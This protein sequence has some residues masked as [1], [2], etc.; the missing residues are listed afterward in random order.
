MIVMCVQFFVGLGSP[1]TTTGTSVFTKQKEA[2]EKQLEKKKTQKIQK[3]RN[4][5]VF[6]E[7]F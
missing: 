1:P 7:G 6:F 3:T 2:A 5:S 4:N